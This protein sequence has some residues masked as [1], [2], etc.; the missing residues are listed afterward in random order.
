MATQFKTVGQAAD[1]LKET[2]TNK[3][4]GA[5]DK[6]GQVGINAIVKLTDWIQTI[7]FDA[8]IAS[9]VKF[10]TDVYNSIMKVVSYV[11]QNSDWLGQ[12]RQV[13]RLGLPLLWQSMER[14]E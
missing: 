9:A 12:S 1:G 11:Q 3:L 2:I 10:G 6:M 13:S 4:Q 8:I 14:L 7:N 5:F